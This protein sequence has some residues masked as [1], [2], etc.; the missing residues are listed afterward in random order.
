MKT[1][2]ISAAALLLSFLISGCLLTGKPPYGEEIILSPNHVQELLEN[3]VMPQT[4]GIKAVQV[5]GGITY[6]GSARLHPNHVAELG[7]LKEGVP[8]VT[9]KGKNDQMKANALLDVSS[10]ASFIE[11]RKSA[12]MGAKILGIN[13][14]VMPY[15]GILN[16]GGVN[17][18][19]AVLPRLRLNMFYIENMPIYVRMA[20]GSLGPLA[21]GMKKPDI[22]MLIGYDCIKN[23]AYI[24]YDLAG[25]RIRISATKPYKPNKQT[26]L[27]TAKLNGNS[28][29]GC[30]V[31][32]AIYGSDTP[33]VLDPVGDY[34][35]ARADFKGPVTKQISLEGV[36][37]RN[38]STIPLPREG[39]YPRVGRRVLER[40]LVTI[41]PQE[42]VVYFERPTR[43]IRR[44]PND[45]GFAIP[46][47]NS[48]TRHTIREVR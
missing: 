15:R 18:F 35:F 31:N 11:V 6:L 23:F 44:D 40:Y 38:V 46:E 29:F 43:L 37:M 16:I 33:I 12:E 4:Y 19:A 14:M 28:R 17:A 5:P 3:T 13:G 45:P 27:T 21:R 41:C 7:L 32:G 30:A 48:F 8:A 20:M 10:P 39:A 36:V 25:N 47:S 26:L 34:T 42:G 1:G 24:Q 2:P 22:H 9:V